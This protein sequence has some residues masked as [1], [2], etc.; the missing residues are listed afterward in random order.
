MALLQWKN[1]YSVGAAAVDD[2]HKKLI[3]RINRLYEQLMAGDEPLAASAFFE[4][5][6]KAITA[7]FVL[8]ERF[9][10][11]R[12]YDQLPQHREDYERLVDDILSLIGEFDRDEEAGR[13]DL[14]SRL[15]GW[16]SCHFETH[17]ARLQEE[18][19]SDPVERATY[20][21]VPGSQGDRVAEL[22]RRKETVTDGDNSAS[23]PLAL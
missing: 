7:H 16:F 23:L 1:H 21:A 19:G 9:M 3:D 12:G 20:G 2:E 15:D 13:D 4:D 22:L 14:A 8:E 17:D 5:L 6:I 10:R 18:F 11:E